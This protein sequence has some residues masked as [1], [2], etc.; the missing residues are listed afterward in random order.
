MARLWEPS[1]ASRMSTREHEMRIALERQQRTFE[2][3]MI[4]SNM[5]TWRYSLADNVCTYD[6]N[7]QRLLRTNAGALSPRQG[8]RGS[9]VPSGRYGSHVGSLCPR[10]SIPRV[11]ADM[12]SSTGVKQLDGSWRWLSAW[13][14]CGVRRPGR[15]AQN[16]SPSP[17][18]AA[19][20]PSEKQAEELQRLLANEAESSCQE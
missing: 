11:M 2:L 16:R 13:G 17:A 8:W 19:I 12:T 5:G 14:P 15:Q 18:Q 1:T 9:Q 20:F 10:R 3:A 7:S 6:E 4:A